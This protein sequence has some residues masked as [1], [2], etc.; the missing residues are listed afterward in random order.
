MTIIFNKDEQEV[1]LNNEGR[2]IVTGF[3]RMILNVST[4]VFVYDSDTEIYHCL[5]NRLEYPKD[6]TLNGL[7]LLLEKGRV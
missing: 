6:L 4:L 1:H 5:K 2:Y 7:N 3:K